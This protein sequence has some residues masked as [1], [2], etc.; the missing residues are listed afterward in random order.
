[1]SGAVDAVDAVSIPGALVLVTNG[2]YQFGGRV[3]DG[4]LTNRVVLN[5]LAEVR[6]V[7]GP[8][9]TIISGNQV[10]GV[11]NGDTAV[12]CAYIKNGAVLSGFTLTNGATRNGSRISDSKLS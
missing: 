12:R 8:A 6:S 7:N 1:M 4:A 3:V 5:K 10:A 2:V 11:T 9:L